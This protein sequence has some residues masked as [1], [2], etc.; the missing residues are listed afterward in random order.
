MSNTQVEQNI[1]LAGEVLV[2]VSKGSAL[3]NGTTIH[4]R[5]LV[6]CQQGV[7]FETLTQGQAIFIYQ[8]DKRNE[9]LS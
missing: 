7:N 1:V 9:V 2:Y 6:H 5:S 4:A 8:T 3:I